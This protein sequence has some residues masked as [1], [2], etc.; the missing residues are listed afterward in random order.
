MIHEICQICQME[1]NMSNGGEYIK[2]KRK[3][4]NALFFGIPKLTRQSRR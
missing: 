1:E 3:T 4:E 2:W